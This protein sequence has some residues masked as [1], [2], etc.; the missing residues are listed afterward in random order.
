[1]YVQ[2][3]YYEKLKSIK[4]KNTIIETGDGEM[5]RKQSK[6]KEMPQYPNANAYILR[7]KIQPKNNNSIQ[8]AEFLCMWKSIQKIAKF[9]L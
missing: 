7:N 1:M 6:G 4:K 8:P 2:L 3:I 5:E 9:N